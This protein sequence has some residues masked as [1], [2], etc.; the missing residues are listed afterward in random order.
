[1]ETLVLVIKTAEPVS[2]SAGK[3]R[4]YIGNRFA[5][6]PILHHHL[7]GYLY[8]Y[9]K[10]QYKVIEGTP[11]ILGIDEGADVLKRISGSI[12][13]LMLGKKRY[14]IESIQMTSIRPRFGVVQNNIEY[15]FLSPWLALSSE[16]YER[17]KLC[18]DWKERK[19]LINSII[20]GNILSMAKGLG[21][22]VDKK[23]F[24]H[25]LLNEE[26]AEYKGIK[27]LS[28]RGSFR[29]NFEIPDF[30]GLGK[31]VSQGFGTVKRAQNKGI[32]EPDSTGNR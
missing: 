22:V 26:Q 11:V 1:M 13:A 31:G 12:D 10:V 7:D 15:R 16:N 24:V 19:N 6:Y 32:K 25:S 5:E 21:Y 2:E 4:G 8:T 17:Y 14:A 20:A 28:F 30:F 23:I 9:P 27:M 18:R 29:A 3:L